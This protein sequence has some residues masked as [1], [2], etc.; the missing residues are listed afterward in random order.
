MASP[1]NPPFRADHVGSLRRPQSLVDARSR[2]R[3]KEIGKA[4]LAKAEDDAI[5]EVV[6]LQE[7]IGLKSITNPSS[8][9]PRPPPL[10]PPLRIARRRSFLRAKFTERI[11]SATSAQRAIRRGFLS[12]IAL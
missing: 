8:Q 6:A 2:Y 7:S 11:T 12:I 10:C 5:R 3:K 4:E 9:I 1:H